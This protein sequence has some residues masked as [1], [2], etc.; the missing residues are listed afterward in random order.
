MS[1][2]QSNIAHRSLKG[3]LSFG[4]LTVFLPLVLFTALAVALAWGLTQNS[5][6]IP[7]TLVGQPVPAFDL[8]PVEGREL[9]LS[10]ADLEGE[11]SLVNVWASWCPPCRREKPLFLE[12]KDAGTVTIHGINYKDRPADAANFL[13]THGDA[14]TRT[15]AD[16]DGRVGIE[17]GVYG[18]R[19]PL[20]STRKE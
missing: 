17:W 15:G 12:L 14:F 19:R 2:T 16:V 6:E 10:S 7:S 3:W 20:S 18:C 9:G 4:R 1:Q 13:D 11:V 5:E 8:P